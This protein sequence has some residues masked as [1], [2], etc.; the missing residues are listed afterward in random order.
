MNT[1]TGMSGATNQLDLIAKLGNSIKALYSHMN[2]YFFNG[3][4]DSWGTPMAKEYLTSVA[5]EINDT[6]IASIN[7]VIP[8]FINSGNAILSALAQYEK[9][10]YPGMTESYTA[11]ESLMVSWEASTDSGAITNEVE[12]KVNDSFVAAN[13]YIEEKLADIITAAE[14][15]GAALSTIDMSAEKQ[16]QANINALASTLGDVITQ[17]KSLNK[18]CQE[19]LIENAKT[20]D[21]NYAEYSGGSA[22]A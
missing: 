9:L 14:D 8:A 20:E 19:S 4:Q 3:I 13:D 17:I 5:N 21:A 2:T 18:Q 22:S 11:I 10:V 7:E 12:K 15:F 16:F 1:G 6:L